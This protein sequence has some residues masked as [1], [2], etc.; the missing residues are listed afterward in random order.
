MQ[1]FIT[2]SNFIRITSKVK[3]DEEDVKQA[4]YKKKIFFFN[5]I[6]EKKILSVKQF[7]INAENGVYEFVEKGFLP[8]TFSFVNEESRYAK[9]HLR[10][11]CEGLLSVYK[12][13]EIPVEIKY[14][15][16]ESKIDTERVSEFRKWFKQEDIQLLFTNDPKKFVDRLQIKFNLQNPPKLVEFGGQGVQGIS[17]LSPAQLETEIEN[18]ISQ[19]SA[20]YA[21]SQ[22]RRKIL[23][24]HGFSKNTYWVTSKKYRAE[25]IKDNKTG[26][27]D[28]EVREVLLEF[29][30]KIKK[31]I[32]GFLID[33]WII[34]LNPGLDFDKNILEQLDFKPCNLC[35][36][37]NITDTLEIDIDDSEPT[38]PLQPD[39]D[40]PF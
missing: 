22:K 25:P 31:P 15:A 9:Y 8:D 6:D 34:K 11:D 32:I 10:K 21:S 17:N 13:F 2:K 33:Y 40:L 30:N 14:K 18:L 1:Y 4:I 7:L 23:V 27:S 29:Y 3:L 24:E 20:H 36:N 28:A 35:T 26:Y 5:R 39:D 16:G 37:Q 19:A 38:E 12:D